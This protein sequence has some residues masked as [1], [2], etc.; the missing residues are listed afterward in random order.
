M[1]LVIFR[2]FWGGALGGFVDGCCRYFFGGGLFKF[3]W[4]FDVVFR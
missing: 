3:K 2:W 1:F 4:L